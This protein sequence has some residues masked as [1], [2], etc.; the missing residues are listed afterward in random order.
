MRK[1]KAF[2][3]MKGY[4]FS[5]E[6]EGKEIKAWFS[7]LSGLEK[8]Y[9]DGELVSSQR[10][11]STNSSNNFKIGPN[12]YSTN[13]KVVSLIKGPFVCTLTKNGR[14]YKRQKLVFHKALVQSKKLPFIVEL[15]FYIVLGGLFGFASS[16]WQLPKDSIYAFLA[17][18]FVVVFFYHRN[19]RKGS[20]PVIEDEGIV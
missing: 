11:I 1:E 15:T 19:S 6:D 12:E 16:H 18:L 4:S 5:F 17:L 13:M 14:E 9:V 8:I 10:N 20:G 7:A 3:L 2:S